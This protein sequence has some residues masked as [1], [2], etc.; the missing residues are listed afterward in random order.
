VSFLI[1]FPFVRRGGTSRDDANEFFVVLLIKSMDNQ[2]NRAC[3]DG[4]NGYPAFLIGG[5][6]VTLRDRAGI[7]ENENGGFK[8]NIMLAKVLAVLVLIPCKS[9]SG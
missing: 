4:P 1:G 7:V 8:A 3:S 9:H 2:Q 6:I 5:G